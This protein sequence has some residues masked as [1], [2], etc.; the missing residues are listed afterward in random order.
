MTVDEKQPAALPPQIER[1]VQAAIATVRSWEISPNGPYGGLARDAID[2][3][4]ADA[5]HA[6]AGPNQRLNHHG[7]GDPPHPDRRK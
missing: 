7:A 1:I 4:L 3:E 2:L 5:V 6:M